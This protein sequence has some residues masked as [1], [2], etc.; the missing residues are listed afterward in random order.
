MARIM[1]EA[2]L[3]RQLTHY[4][5]LLDAD[6]ALGKIPAANQAREAAQQKL[7][8]IRAALAAGERIAAFLEV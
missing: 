5:R 7:Q 1:P 3:Y 4:H 8:P 6:S 2:A